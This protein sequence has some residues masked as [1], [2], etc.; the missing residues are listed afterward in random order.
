MF[1]EVYL[2]DAPYSLDRPFDYECG[3]GI[4]VGSIV[5]VPFGRSNGLRLGVVTGLKSEPSPSDGERAVNIKP[6][7]SVWREIFALTEEMLGLC[8]FMKE[9][10][11]CT[12][13]EAVRTVLPPGALSPALNIKSRRICSLRISREACA[14]LL[15]ETGRAGIK[16][17]G[18]RRALLYLLD[19]TSADAEL[20]RAQPGVTSAHIKA[21]S[22][23]GLIAISDEEM[24]RNPY[25]SYAVGAE[26]TEIVLSAAQ[27]TAYAEI[28]RLYSEDEARAA[29]L[30]G[31]TGSGK[32][33]VIMNAIDRT[34]DDG[35]SVIMLVPEISLTPQTVSIFCKRYGERVAV[36]HSGLSQGERMDAWRRARRGDVDL[37]IGTRSAIFAPLENIG[38][39]VIDEEHEH[40]YKSE[41][42]P[43]YHARDI[44]AFR[45]GRHKALMLL[46]SATPAIESFYKAKAG[47]YKLIPLRERY[48]GVRLPDAVIVDMREE[49][50][51]GNLSPI[52]KRL[53]ESL[54]G[55]RERD[56]QAIIF[57]NRRGYSS[58]ISCKECGEVLSCPRC[59][60][61]LTYHATG[62]GKLL[63]HL[64]G[65]TAP[66]PRACACGSEKLSFLGYG[67]QK[68]EA[69]LDKYLPDMPV[70]RMDADTTTGKLVY[71]KLLEDF[72]GGS[73]DILLGTQM[74]AKGHDFP[75]VTLV[76]VALADTSLY[77]SDFRAAERTFSLLTQVI[78]RAGRASDTGV[79]VIQT[80]SPMNEVIRLACKQ[81]YESFYEGEI[82]LRRELQYPP[83][84]DMV[85]LTL[86]ASDEVSLGRA[87]A[88]L[89]DELLK[90][91]GG[92]WADLP[93][94]VFGP[95]EAQVYKLNE[96]YRMRTVVKC[97]LSA[98]TRA[99]FSELLSAFSSDRDATLTVD[100]N[101]LT[102]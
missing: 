37:V 67:T 92:R 91:V 2:L 87:S 54:E 18:Q 69:E 4:T 88:R 6:V 26:R 19:V 71:D 49:L 62:R 14:T 89:N 40:T 27:R 3:E 55:V 20:L 32:T 68:L 39:I 5:R 78:G 80:F 17:E 86:T 65:Y 23:K 9:H 85:Q 44:A 72:R 15:S 7:H 70:M 1:C 48:G 63:C 58:Q 74:V 82:A 66:V 57:L 83:F 60:V 41:S 16:S 30:F 34:I 53:L 52:S 98:R 46:A 96:K 8:L 61:S 10:T 64:C 76:G 97:K 100:L 75:R 38:L 77:L 94:V 25:S 43:K 36:V 11:L 90:R 12:L 31:V 59:S 28:E 99:L 56:E 81:D 45:C 73:A 50:R 95:F 29:L 22:D 33:K 47:R 101:P 93:F 42:D 51:Q 13:G 102:V 84:C 24:I 21:L 35:R 79:A